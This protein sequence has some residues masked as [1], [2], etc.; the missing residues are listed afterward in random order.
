[1]IA[2]RLRNKVNLPLLLSLNDIL[3]NAAKFVS[4]SACDCSLSSVVIVMLCWFWLGIKD[5]LNFYCKLQ[6]KGTLSRPLFFYY[7][8]ISKIRN[9]DASQRSQCLL[10]RHCRRHLDQSTQSRHES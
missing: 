9:R 3:L 8:K 10:H 2:L 5:Y 1:M 4:T 6:K 7:T